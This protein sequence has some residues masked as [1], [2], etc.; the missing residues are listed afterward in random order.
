M[1][2]YKIM[3][4]YLTIVL[5]ICMLVFI[6]IFPTANSSDVE[7]NNL[8]ISISAGLFG[9]DF[10]WGIHIKINNPEST[11]FIAFINI[12]YDAIIGGKID[13]AHRNYTVLPNTEWTTHIHIGP[14]AIFN[15]VDISVE[16]G[17]TAAS[18]QGFSIKSFNILTK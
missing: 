5:V 11:E 4:K 14:R 1:G 8:D 13:T 12:T 6:S 2:G 17:E 15:Q 3:R 10:G 16:V 18:R 7:K 9:L